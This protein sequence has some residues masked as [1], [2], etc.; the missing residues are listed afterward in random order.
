[1][2]AYKM[3]PREGTCTFQKI[4]HGKKWVGRVCQHADGHW[5]G[6]IKGSVMAYGPTPVAAF[7][8]T[9]AKHLGYASASALHARNAE[10][11]AANRAR[12]QS[13]RAIARRFLNGDLKEKMAVLDELFVNIESG[14]QR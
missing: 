3:Q 7:E 10:V 12:R 14:R 1:M 9:V 13:S 11:R 6:I 2:T 4:T 8:A 5:V